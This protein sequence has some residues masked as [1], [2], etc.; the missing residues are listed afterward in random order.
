MKG[1]K[2]NLKCVKGT[3]FSQNRCS[4]THFIKESVT[5]S[6]LIIWKCHVVVL[7]SWV[8]YLVLFWATRVS[9]FCCLFFINWHWASVIW[10]SG[11]SP[12]HLFWYVFYGR[13]RCQNISNGKIIIFDLFFSSVDVSQTALAEWL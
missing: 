2:T 6:G 13:F 1:I 9:S 7:N 8:M 11:W 3:Y 10:F 12:E 5:N 4:N